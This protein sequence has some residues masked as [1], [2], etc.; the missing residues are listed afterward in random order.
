MKLASTVITFNGPRLLLVKR[1]SSAR[2]M[3]NRTVFPGGVQE[4]AD[5]TFFGVGMYAAA[6][7]AVGI[8]G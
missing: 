4:E 7:A 1:K 3:A 6:C 5:A 8:A 2:F